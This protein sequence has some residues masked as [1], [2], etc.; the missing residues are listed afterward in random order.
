MSAPPSLALGWT[1]MTGHRDPTSHWRLPVGRPQP[2][3]PPVK[4]DTRLTEIKAHFLTRTPQKARRSL[5]GTGCVLIVQAE[6]FSIP[7]AV[8]DPMGM[9]PGQHLG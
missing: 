8:L 4:A 7:K 5:H 1:T 9:V 3:Q 6:G 2:S